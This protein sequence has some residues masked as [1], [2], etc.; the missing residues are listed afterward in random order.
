MVDINISWDMIVGAGILIIIFFWII[1]RIQRQT[2]KETIKD[3][4]DIIKMEE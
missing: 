4:V 3:T 2:M 1:S